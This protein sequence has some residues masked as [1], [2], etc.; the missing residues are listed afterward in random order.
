MVKKNMKKKPNYQSL[1]YQRRDSSIN[2]KVW[3][4]KER[5]IHTHKEAHGKS[6]RRRE[7]K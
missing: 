5:E 3:K 6:G 4:R 7:R 2:T 1:I